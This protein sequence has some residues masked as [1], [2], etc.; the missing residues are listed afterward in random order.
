MKKRIILLSVI[1]STATLLLAQVPP[2]PQGGPDSG[3]T[4]V[5]GVITSHSIHYTKLY[6]HFKIKRIGHHNQ[7]VNS[8]SNTININKVIV[9]PLLISHPVF[10]TVSK[11]NPVERQIITVYMQ[12]VI[13]SYSIHYTKLYE[14]RS[15]Y[16]H[17][18]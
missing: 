1:L 3:N 4:P 16:S 8:K 12:C 5:G 9:H 10:I 14:I 11:V 17:H 2:T 6:D 13:T 7:V 15:M 18:G